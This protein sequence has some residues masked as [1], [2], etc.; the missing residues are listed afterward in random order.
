[1]DEVDGN[2]DGRC[3]GSHSGADGVGVWV[4]ADVVIVI[5]DEDRGGRGW[6]NA[7]WIKQQQLLH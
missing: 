2:N 1:M 5:V 3:G 4:D 6:R 7:A